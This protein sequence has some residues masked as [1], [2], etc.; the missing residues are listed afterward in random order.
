MLWEIDITPLPGHID[1]DG[2]NVASD[3]QDMGIADALTVHSVR[4]Y[5][6]QGNI[7]RTE[8]EDLALT[9]L[10]DGVVES[11]R[12]APVGDAIFQQPPNGCEQVLHV[13]RKPGVMDPVAQSAQEAIRER[14]LSVDAMRTFRKYWLGV[15]PEQA[16]DRLAM[17]VLA[18]DSIELVVKGNLHLE[19][20]D[21]GS[22]YT[23]ELTHV[24]IRDLTDE[25]LESLSI[26]GQLYLSLTEMQTIQQHF[27]EL[28]R[29]P[30]DIELETIAQTWS[31]H[32]SHKTLAGR[33]AYPRRKGR[34]TFYEHVEGNHFR[35]H[36]RDS[37]K[38]R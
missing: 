25:Q 5:L 24:P 6:I 30:T 3:A 38:A 14:G 32:C 22:P 1:K 18:N 13:L 17:K 11:V 34:A 26:T 4:G 35:G 19:R 20:L 23:F 16:V 7:Q 12:V 29:E 21:L 2:R 33:I 31:E 15:M 10:A 8:M 36:C 9:L 28:D 27:L 37:S